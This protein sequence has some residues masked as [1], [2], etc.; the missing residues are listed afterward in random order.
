M[1]AMVAFVNQYGNV[2]NYHHGTDSPFGDLF[3]RYL[4]DQSIPSSGACFLLCRVQ[5]QP[6]H[7]PNRTNFGMGWN[8]IMFVNLLMYFNADDLAYQV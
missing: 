3:C 7:T 8:V 6:G 5:V 2:S 1:I 4:E